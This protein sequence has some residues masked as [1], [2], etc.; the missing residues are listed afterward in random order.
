[1]FNF[2]HKVS[3][4]KVSCWNASSVLVEYFGKQ[5]LREVVFKIFLLSAYSRQGSDLGTGDSAGKK[6]KC[7]LR[8][9]TYGLGD[10]CVIQVAS[11]HSIHLNRPRRRPSLRNKSDHFKNIQIDFSL[12]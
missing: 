2:S 6:Y 11:M 9:L 1:M 12:N 10:C 7:L 4:I 5:D 3:D 8:A